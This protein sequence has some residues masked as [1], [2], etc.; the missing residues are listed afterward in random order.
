VNKEYRFKVRGTNAAG[1]GPW[2]T[3]SYFT[4]FCGGAVTNITSPLGCVAST[5]PTFTWLPV[6]GADNYW[7]LAAPTPDFSAGPLVVNVNTGTQTSYSPGAVFT[8]NTTYYAKV[9]THVAP[10]S[11]AGGWSPTI[12]FTPGCTPQPPLSR[13][14]GP[15]VGTTGLPIQF[16]GS[17]SSDPDG[18]VVSY[19][20]SF[21]DGGSATGARPTHAFALDG[22]YTVTLTVTDNSGMTDRASTTADTRPPAPGEPVVWTNVV[23]VSVSGNNL[24]NTAAVDNWTSGASSTRA[25]TSGN[26]GVAFRVA[27]T[28]TYRMLGLSHLD[29]DAGYRSLDFAIYTTSAGTLFV[30]ESGASAGSFGTYATG[31][32]LE[33]VIQANTVRYKRNGVIFYS[34]AGRPVF[35]LVV[36]TSL[37]SLGAATINQVT[38]SGSL[39]PAPPIEKVAWTNATGVTVSGNNLTGNG[40]DGWSSGAFST[41]GIASGDGFATFM[42]KETNTYRML[43]LSHADAGSS[44]TTIDF[45]LYATAAGTLMVYEKGASM[46]Q[47]GTYAA[48]DRLEVAI[49]NGV[50]QYLNNGT[51]LYTS[52]QVPVYPLYVDTS[53]YSSGAT[54]R[55]A[56]IGGQLTPEIFSSSVPIVWTNTAGVSVSGSSLTKTAVAGW[57]NAGAS[58][59]KAIASGDGYAEFTATDTVNARMLGLSH[60][61]VDQMYGSIDF[62]LY[63]TNKLLQVYERGEL[64]GSFGAYALGDRLRV[65]VQGG[66]VSY[67]RNG[68]VFYTSTQA[69]SYPLVADVAIYSPSSGVTDAAMAGLLADSAPIVPVSW[70]K[71][72]GVSISGNSLTMTAPSGWGNAGASSTQAIASGDGFVD[73]LATE[74]SSARMVGFSRADPDASYTSIEFALYAANTVLQVYERGVLRGTFGSYAPGDHLQVVVTSGV[75]RYQRNG[76][77]LYT[78]SQVPAY[79]LLVD[80]ALYPTG[81]SIDRVMLSGQLVSSPP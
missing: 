46:G 34:S 3:I 18:T 59:T 73:F 51:L 66:V 37:Y 64:K 29:V 55:D 25:I 41:R 67:L 76:M 22:L 39:G 27:E 31:D 7:L 26:G 4:P 33:I 61:D 78:S 21:G 79:P 54:I 62:A 80:T 44:Y 42:A 75:V 50:V 12:S 6:T 81:Y 32:V 5:A 53:L 58:S 72:V 43:G 57:G 8:P 19:L 77:V 56:T 49:R 1:I 10:D 36:D 30:Y 14:G 63:A 65:A 11:V 23:G 60:M 48:G 74:N 40:P 17:T 71:A 70:T 28:N 45:A 68:T 2:S 69:P 13:P 52:T 20:W 16:D 38:L 9:K 35:P 15:Y 47:F 24:T